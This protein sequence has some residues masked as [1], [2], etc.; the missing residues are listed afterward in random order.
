MIVTAT[1]ALQK[2]RELA[3]EQNARV[4][5]RK[6]NSRWQVHRAVERL[7]QYGQMLR[8]EGSV[9]NQPAEEWLLDHLDFLAQQG[10]L[11]E[12]TLAVRPL[13]IARLKGGEPRIAVL[14][15]AY[16]D[17]VDGAFEQESFADFVNAFQNVSVLTQAEL[18]SLPVYLRAVLLIRLS[19]VM[20]RVRARRE[21][22]NRV[23]QWLAVVAPAGKEPRPGALR[24][25]LEGAGEALPMAGA[26]LV[27]LVEQLREYTDDEAELREWL[28]CRLESGTAD[29]DRL[30]SYE[31]RLQSE[32]QVQSGN[33]ITS[34]H[35]L[36]KLDFR[37]YADVINVVDKTL[38]DEAA[39]T[40][41]RLDFVSRDR[42]RQR[43]GHL[44][45]SL[46]VPEQLVAEQAVALA[47]RA[48]QESSQ[49]LDDAPRAC[50]VPYYL[51]DPVGVGAL[52]KAL[53]ACA[54][55]RRAT[56]VGRLPNR[57][58]YYLATVITLCVAFLLIFVGWLY[59]DDPENWRSPGWLGVVVAA[60]VPASQWAVSVAHWLIETRIRT[61]PLL[62]LDYSQGVDKEASTLV[63]IPVIWS[64]EDEV[65][66]LV[67]RLE[68]HYLANRDP[69]IHFAILGDFADATQES[70]S[71]D[72]A[73]LRAA[74]SAIEELA[75]RYANAGSTFHL[76][77]RRR[78][79]N[80]AE[81]VWMG[82][83]RKRGKL[84]EFV[85]WLQGSD[86]TSYDVVVGPR[87]IWSSIRYVIT[88]DTDT[89]LPMGSAMRMIGTIALPYNKPRLNAQGTRVAEGYGVLQPRVGIKHEAVM[90]SRLAALWAGDPGIDPYAFAVSDPYQDLLGQGIFTGKGIFDVST[91]G[92][93]LCQRIPEN[94]VL[95][96]DLLEGGFLRAGLLADI[97]VIDDHPGTYTAYQARL[98]RWIRG[99]WQLLDWLRHRTPDRQGKPARVPLSALTRWQ[100][101]D[102]LRR[103]LMQPALF[104]VLLFGLTSLPG[105]PSH[106]VIL[107]AVTLGL[108]ILRRV[109]HPMQIV[110]HPRHVGIAAA[111]ALVI[112]L[113]LPFETA[114]ALD[115]IGRT[116][117][118]LY[119]SHRHLLEWV[120]SAEVERRHNRRHERA[121]LREPF[122]YLLVAIFAVWVGWQAPNADV[123][124]AGLLLSVIWAF[125]PAYVR[126]LDK[127]LVRPR[128]PLS[129]QERQQ[130]IGLAR[131]IWDF[132]ETFANDR[133]HFLP[134]DNVQLE[135]DVGVAARTSPTNIA[136]LLASTVA[137]CD[138][139]LIDRKGMRERL[140]RT[141]TTVEAMEKWHG[142]LYNWYDTRTLRPLQPLYVSTV[143]SGNLVA[144]LIAVREAVLEAD[145]GQDELG[146][147]LEALITA[148]DFRP[149]YDHRA[150]LFTL[151][152]HVDIEERESILY[153]LLASEA[154]Q[155][156]LVAIALGQ[157]SAAHWLALGRSLV[158][159]GGHPTL[160]SW[161]GT[162]FEYFMPPLFMKVYG[163]TL[164]D[165][166]YRGA[167]SRQQQYAQAHGVP[168][169]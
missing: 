109:L 118:R 119:V 20:L 122:G 10:L 92:A 29:L 37:M 33:L 1:V 26:V 147:R 30:V 131:E 79:Y 160:L 63:A 102:N 27:Q 161:S 95:S 11:A 2:A 167:L 107:L 139:G 162:M 69:H 14:C 100:I 4:S 129:E 38:R 114:L 87:E 80:E 76:L 91:F 168:W 35:R 64:S 150:K 13:Q 148:T 75:Q 94:R 47:N 40:Y 6:D 77:H 141:L 51:L 84:V 65:A 138:L 98:H 106:Y 71:G 164:W 24:Q 28:S 157:V 23:A 133:E 115:A 83:E 93:V 136:L 99:D 53:R 155:A 163:K 156:S 101:I 128:R 36:D 153:D 134:P 56:T 5:R 32:Q 41:A 49:S 7:Q 52:V 67:Q 39:G 154:R 31:H 59:D 18:W 50:Y 169:G 124:V 45:K 15:D 146:A 66:E 46:R 90:R 137:A 70:Q 22:G 62:R 103:S 108:P 126:M 127:P 144:A 97:E 120:S 104:I 74:H 86:T 55:P 112:A 21:A 68:M 88:L 121:L 117:W 57:A 132:F 60:F 135:P 123:R 48:W 145:D 166:T 54:S 165:E 3:L 17:T 58:G 82:W 78:L 25:A 42:L 149:L 96:H 125:A 8:A 110:R 43:V 34:L 152:Y 61:K 9:D 73:L 16:L 116:L 113:L 151:G 140:D 105:R 158:K 111:Q 81:G 72:A 12:R 130:M 85:E 159:A 19:E 143:D 89:Q 142:H 44:A